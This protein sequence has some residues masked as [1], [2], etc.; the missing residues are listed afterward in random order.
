M[1]EILALGVTEGHGLEVSWWLL[2]RFA[3]ARTKVKSC[4]INEILGI[5]FLGMIKLSPKKMDLLPHGYPDQ[6]WVN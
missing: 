5:R 6:L 1:S 3:S 2:V 4:P